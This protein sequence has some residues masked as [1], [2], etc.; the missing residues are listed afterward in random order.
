VVRES[1]KDFVNVKVNLGGDL[2][3]CEDV[4]KL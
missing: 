2:C 3:F 4:C 1:T